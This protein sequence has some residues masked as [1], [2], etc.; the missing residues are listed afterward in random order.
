VGI[1]LGISIGAPPPNAALKALFGAIG[2]WI[3]AAMLEI[4]LLAIN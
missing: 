3:K 4:G 2:F 1:G